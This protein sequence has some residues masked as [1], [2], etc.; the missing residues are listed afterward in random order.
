MEWL[1]NLSASLAEAVSLAVFRPKMPKTRR[2]AWGLLVPVFVTLVHFVEHSQ[3]VSASTFLGF[4]FMNVVVTIVVSIAVDW[5]NKR[6]AQ[7]ASD[8]I[9]QLTEEENE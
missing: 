2:V 4:N 7:K 9:R 1:A 5:R 6:V 3:F 8:R